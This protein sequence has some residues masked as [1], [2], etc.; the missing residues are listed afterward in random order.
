MYKILYKRF[1]I[2]LYVGVACWLE[3]TW[4]K[5]KPIVQ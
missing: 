1:H 5:P 3:R 2:E 4:I